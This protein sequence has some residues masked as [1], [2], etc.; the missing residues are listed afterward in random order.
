MNEHSATP[1]NGWRLGKEISLPLV[2]AII[3]QTIFFVAWLTTLSSN[4]SQGTTNILEL[5]ADRYTKADAA[6]DKE[7]TDLKFA[8]QGLI[9]S[10]QLR[11]IADLESRM[12]VDQP[13]RSGR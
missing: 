1:G 3:V 5:K 13:T 2:F 9:L 6:K 4:V 7:L 11:R 8:T 10:D 12:R